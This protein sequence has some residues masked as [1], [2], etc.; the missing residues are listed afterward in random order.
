MQVG[1]GKNLTNPLQSNTEKIIL[2]E[3]NIKITKENIILKVSEVLI[4]FKFQ[5]LLILKYNL[6]ML[7][8]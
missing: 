7:N 1:T 6:K 2:N 3:K 4:M 5:N 8:V